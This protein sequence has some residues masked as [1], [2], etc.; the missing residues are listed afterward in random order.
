MPEEYEATDYEEV[1]AY[2]VGQEYDPDAAWDDLNMMRRI[3]RRPV[4]T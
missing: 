1:T 4:I 3:K 2:E